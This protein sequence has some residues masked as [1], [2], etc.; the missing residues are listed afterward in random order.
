MLPKVRDGHGEG[1]M[2]PDQL[3]VYAHFFCT[4]GHSGWNLQPCF[5]V[6]NSGMFGDLAAML[7]FAGQVAKCW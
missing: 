5:S 2:N 6:E 7:M 4:G 3:M 1:G